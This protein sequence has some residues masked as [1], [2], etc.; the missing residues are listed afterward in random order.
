[1]REPDAVKARPDISSVVSEADTAG[2]NGERRA[3]RELPD[4]QEGKQASKSLGTVNLLQV[5]IGAAGLRHG[6]TEFGPYQAVGKREQRAGNPAQYG[7]RASGGGYDQWQRDERADADHI[8][9]VQRGG[10]GKADAANQF[11]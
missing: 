7:L 2:G 5:L 9:H 4:K 11:G 10:A 3:E 8:N 6:S 1:M